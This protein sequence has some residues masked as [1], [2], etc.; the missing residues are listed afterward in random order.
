MGQRKETENLKVIAIH[1]I[2]RLPALIC[3]ID[4]DFHLNRI[5]LNQVPN[6]QTHLVPY[7]Q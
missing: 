1:Q 7:L 2:R 5:K 4:L 6:T 3:Q